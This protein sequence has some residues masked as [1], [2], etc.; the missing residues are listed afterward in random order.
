MIK[1]LIRRHKKKVELL[2][3]EVERPVP[4]RKKYSP[5]IAL[6]SFWG[7][8]VTYVPIISRADG[9]IDP[10]ILVVFG[11]LKSDEVD[12]YEDAEALGCEFMEWWSE[13]LKYYE[14]RR[15]VKK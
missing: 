2:I 6:Y 15:F 11:G 4:Y 9:F 14:R 1:E 5:V 3:Q 13:R 10:S 7:L 8:C 12:T